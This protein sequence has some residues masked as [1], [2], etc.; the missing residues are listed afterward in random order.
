[1]VHVFPGSAETL[2]MRGGIRNNHLI[3]YSVRNIS[4]RNYQNRLM[5]GEVIKCNISVIFWDTVYTKCNKATV[6]D[7][8][9]R[10][11]SPCA[12]YHAD[13]WMSTF[14][15]QHDGYDAACNIHTYTYM[16]FNSC[17]SLVLLRVRTDLGTDSE[18]HPV[19]CRLNLYRSIFLDRHWSNCTSN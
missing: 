16:S 12:V 15:V 5:R 19:H 10:M 9:R 7:L 14:N 3:V 6:A 18:P 2:V 8:V 17:G 11:R 13:C 1:M 4:A